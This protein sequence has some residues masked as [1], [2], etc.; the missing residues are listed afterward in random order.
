MT[1]RRYRK[2][3]RAEQEAETRRRIVRAAVALHGEAGPR[4]T[5][6]SAVA[7]RAGVQRLTVYR[8]FPDLASL[9]S[10]CT[11]HW[12]GENP[13]P[14]PGDW[15]DRVEPAERTRAALTALYAYYRETEYM[16]HR[17][18]RDLDTV[19]ALHAP[20]AAFER[21]LDGIRD[22]LVTAWYGTRTAPRLTTV[23]GHAVRFRSWQTLASEGLA[24]EVLADLV[25]RWA[26][27]VADLD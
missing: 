26:A 16:W 3:R 11:E 5:T 14:S 27:V 13:P 25:T 22:D 7:E 12:L 19:P 17:A 20:M 10:T 9:F 15:V 21:H 4:D 24:V 6:I 23:L 18:Y 2:Q 1:Q 8:H